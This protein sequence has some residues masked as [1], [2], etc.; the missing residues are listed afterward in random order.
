MNKKIL[1]KY[2]LDIRNKQSSVY[3]GVYKS[4]KKW[5]AKIKSIYLGTFETE[6]EAA[7]MYDKW[8]K[9]LYGTF[10]HINVSKTG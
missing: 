1:E 8:A 2:L 5:M 6:L 10:A 9:M 3:K 4:G 7:K